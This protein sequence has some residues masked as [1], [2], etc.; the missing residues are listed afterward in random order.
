MPT[1]VSR[2]PKFGFQAKSSS[3]GAHAAPAPSAEMTSTRLTNG[4]Y[5]HPGPA[6]V[7][8][9][10]GGSSPS[11]KQKGFLRA[12]AS[13]ATNYEQERGGDEGKRGNACQSR[14]TNNHQAHPAS[15]QQSNRTAAGKGRV[16]NHT[17]QPAP[18][19]SSKLQTA[20]NL[21]N[22]SKQA[23]SRP[24]TGRGGSLRRPQ[25]FARP[26]G[27]GS[28]LQKKQASRS[29]SSDD[30]GSAPP[31]QLTHNDRFRSQSLNQVR[32]QASPTLSPSP[33][34]S[35]SP[36][37]PTRSYLFSKSRLKPAPSPQARA[38]IGIPSIPPGSLKKPLL[39]SIGP[40]PRN[41]GISYKLSRPSL[42]KQVRPLRVTPV[43]AS[44]GDQDVNK[45]V[46][47]TPP[48]TGNSQSGLFWRRRCNFLNIYMKKINVSLIFNRGDDT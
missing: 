5:H 34:S 22:G 1:M 44:E 42:N 3:G 10:G 25:S 39:P 6:G 41:G 43:R 8:G 32:R 19:D 35:S 14:S 31:A 7:N 29:H 33:A 12:P 40:S 23:P 36:V 30:L 13:F 37:P 18:K 17:P 4:F 15:P 48:T 24:W 11:A 2:L 47:E 28:P 9:A 16:L 38:G 21:A 26:A 46:S 20:A 27:P 45:T